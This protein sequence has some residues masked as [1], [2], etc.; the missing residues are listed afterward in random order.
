MNGTNAYEGTVEVFQGGS[1]DVLRSDNWD[2]ND[3]AAV[4]RMLGYHKALAAPLSEYFCEPD[5]LI[6]DLET[7]GWSSHYQMPVPMPTLPA[8]IY[9]C[10]DGSVAG[11]ICGLRNISGKQ[12][13]FILHLNFSTTSN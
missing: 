9:D 10:P 5:F 2:L 4:C 6:P 1:W 11:A 7:S 8:F 13:S 12:R 3:A